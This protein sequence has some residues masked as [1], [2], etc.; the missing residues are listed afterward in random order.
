MSNLARKLLYLLVAMLLFPAASASVPQGLTLVGKAELSILWW[1]IYD[2]ELYSQTG[3]YVPQ[4]KPLLLKISYKRAISRDDLLEE[5]LAQWQRF[6]IAAEKKQEWLTQL[7]Q[8]WP[9]VKASDN[10]SF[11][12][13]ASGSCHFY[14]NDTFIGRVDDASFSH[15]FANIWLDENGP[16]P[17]MTSALL[18]KTEY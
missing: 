16:Y 4:Q 17:D 3:S 2:A 8:F 18:G 12:I 5:T 11:Y 15:Y 9:D 6:N 13:D 7:A 14:F 1:D 10:I